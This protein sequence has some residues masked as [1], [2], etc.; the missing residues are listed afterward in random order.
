VNVKS[1][2]VLANTI[3]NDERAKENNVVLSVTH[4]FNSLTATLDMITHLDSEGVNT[5]VENPLVKNLREFLQGCG[6]E[7]EN[8][9]METM[10]DDE[11]ALI[12]KL[13]QD[14]IDDFAFEPLYDVLRMDSTLME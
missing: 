12:A 4:V 1:F 6:D 9:K 8:E 2:L 14:R 7:N 5:K 11:V 3:I 13:R 10:Q